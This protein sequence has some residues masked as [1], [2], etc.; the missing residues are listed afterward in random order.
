VALLAHL[1]L[2]LLERYKRHATDNGRQ[3]AAFLGVVKIAGIPAWHAGLVL[4]VLLP[5]VLAVFFP[6]L[7]WA[8]IPVLAGLCLYEY[9][10]VRA[11]Q[12]PPLS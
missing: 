12:L 7:W 3:A 1:V 2:A 10:Y 4:G 6:Y 11:A 5:C 8:A 9:A